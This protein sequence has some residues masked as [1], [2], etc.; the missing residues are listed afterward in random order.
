VAVK[1]GDRYVITG[2]KMWISLADVADH[3]LVFAWTDQ[4]KKKER[5]PSGMSAFIVERGFAGF[6]SGTL[7]QKW[8]ILA[9]NTGFIK[10]DAVEV[11][12]EN[13]VGA[14]AR[15]SRSRCSRSTRAA[16]PWPPARPG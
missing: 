13:R 5:D 16:S 2:E 11:P 3:V 4:S 6:S 10:L 9:G 14:K 8:G 12:E 7:T 1:K 15:A